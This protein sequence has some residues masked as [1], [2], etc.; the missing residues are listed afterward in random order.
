VT[1]IATIGENQIVASG[2]TETLITQQPYAGK[3]FRAQHQN[4]GAWFP[5]DDQ[6]LMFRLNRCS[7]NNAAE[8]TAYFL[9]SKK[10]GNFNVGAGS[11]RNR[12]T[13]NFSYDE[14][15]FRADDMTPGRG[16]GIQYEYKA[17]P[18]GSSIDATY[19]RF[20]KNNKT[21]LGS[22][23]EIVS[24]GDTTADFAVKATLSSISEKIAPVFD[25]NRVGMVAIKNVVNN[26]E[27]SNNDFVIVSGGA[28]YTEGDTINVISVKSG[29]FGAN[30][31]VWENE[32]FT[33]NATGGVITGIWQRPGSTSGTKYLDSPLANVVSTSA[34]S[35]ADIRIHGETNSHGGNAKARY[36]SKTVTLADGF[37]A[38]DIRVYLSAHKPT[39]TDIGVYY[40]VKN[41][42]DGGKI[43]DNDWVLMKQKTPESEASVS[44]GQSWIYNEI[45]YVPYGSEIS[46]NP[47]SYKDTY[48]RVHSS[49]Y[50]FKIK[51][52]MITNNTTIVPKV[53]D[54]RAIALE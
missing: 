34:T 4:G 26:A 46:D 33:V 54:L 24:D 19:K 38:N 29:T 23:H 17:K 45:E 12:L 8:T 9:L 10:F 13:K 43:E 5:R 6:D 48:D 20:G 53:K 36:I 16:S 27:L 15:Y 37:D 14:F 52:V 32:T 1:Y 49:F 22:R 41:K 51:I 2:T 25:I 31:A 35:R 18:V 30:G 11:N 39:G 50:Q 44:G 42:D 40:K 3:L 7:F 28:D 47:I 21:Q